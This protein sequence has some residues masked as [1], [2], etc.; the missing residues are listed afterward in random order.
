MKNPVCEMFGI[1]VPIFAFSHCRNVVSE[2]SRAGGMGVLGASA[3]TPDQLEIELA[4][5]DEHVGDRPYGVDVLI[6]SSYERID[7]EQMAQASRE[8][9]PEQHRRFVEELLARHGVPE[10]SEADRQAQLQRYL[11]GNTITPEEAAVRLEVIFRHPRIRLLVSA[12]GPAPEAVVARAR[13]VGMKI[14]GLAGQKRHARKQ[15]EAGADLVIAT[16]YEA[17]G[18]TGDISTMVLVPEVVDEI[19]P[20]PVLAAGGIGRGRQIAASLA[21]G[22]QGVWCGTIWLGSVES[23][24]SPSLKSKLFA[25]SSSDTRKTRCNSGKPARRLRSAWVDAWEA[26]GA[27][28]P[29]P[30]PLQGLLTQEPLERIR[31]YDAVDLMTYPAGQVVGQLQHEQTVRGIIGD[32]LDEFADT[33]DKLNRWVE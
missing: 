31:R 18:H 6:P 2:A 10:L 1:D 9:L 5:L 3:F 32:M 21:L 16:G 22:A 17:G 13:G 19:A 33:V 27:P 26:P 4:W 23:E 28:E 29:L 14:G 7:R 12:L 11:T 20:I 30:M 15:V 8:K 25:S 24:V